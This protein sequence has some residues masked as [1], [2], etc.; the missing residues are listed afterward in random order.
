MDQL[1]GKFEVILGLFFKNYNEK[2]HS[3]NSLYCPPIKCETHR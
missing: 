3:G 1:T 2:L